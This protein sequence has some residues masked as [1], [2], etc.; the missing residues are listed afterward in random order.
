LFD[1]EQFG[2]GTQYAILRDL[3]VVEHR[4]CYA[5]ILLQQ[6]SACSDDICG[7]RSTEP[8][9]VS[10]RD[11]ALQL[12]PQR[13]VFR[14]TGLVQHVLRGHV[15]CEAWCEDG[16]TSRDACVLFARPQEA[17]VLVFDLRK[18]CRLTLGGE[19]AVQGG[20]NRIEQR[21]YGQ[22]DLPSAMR[23]RVACIES[24]L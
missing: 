4:L 19:R 5:Q 3:A 15:G 11:I 7:F 16:L 2:A 12:T 24:K 18:V 1:I 9:E 20:I 17:D 23:A 6:R 14:M 22:I 13:N 8:V 21:T 10:D